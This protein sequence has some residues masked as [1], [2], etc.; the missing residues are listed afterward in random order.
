MLHRKGCVKLQC[1]TRKCSV[2]CLP[3]DPAIQYL[4]TKRSIS[5]LHV[6]IKRYKNRQNKYQKI[7][8]LNCI[9]PFSICAAVAQKWKSVFMAVRRRWLGNNQIGNCDSCYANV[10]CNER[11]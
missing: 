5:I 8:I 7:Y 2:Y 3:S 6:S 9:I 10:E 11:A 4:P 1:Y